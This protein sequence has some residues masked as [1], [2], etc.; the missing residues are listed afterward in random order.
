MVV[1][2]SSCNVEKGAIPHGV[3]Q[4][5]LDRD[6]ECTGEHSKDTT[7]APDTKWVTGEAREKGGAWKGRKE[8]QE[9]EDNLD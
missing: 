5:T 3:R 1:M 4:E 8:K 7:E 9:K 6:L 2:T